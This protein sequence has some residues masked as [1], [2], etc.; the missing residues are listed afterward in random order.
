M[1]YETR[2]VHGGRSHDGDIKGTS[3]PIHMSSTY[4][5][6]T[7]EEFGEFGY[8]RS[9]NPTRDNVEKQVAQ[10][11]GANYALSFSSGM[12]A[13]TLALSHLKPGETLLINNNVYGGTWSLI[14]DFL[15]EKD[16]NIEIVTNFNELD[17][18]SLGPDVSTIFLET[19]SNP[20]LEI[21]DI[22]KVTQH[23]KKSGITVIVD[24]TFMTSYLQKPLDLGADMVVYSATK[25]Y[26]GHADLLAG[27]L[28]L[29]DNDLYQELKFIQKHLGSI[30]SPF[31]S[32]LLNRGI[33][34][35]PL[36]MDRQ[37]KNT[38]AI[39]NFL[40]GQEINAGLYYPGLS[41]NAGY[42]IQ[43]KQARGNGALFS[44]LV[45]E[46]YDVDKFCTS[47]EIFDLAVSLGGIESLVCVPAMMTHETYSQ[48]HLD[49]IGITKN[50]VRFAVGVENVEDLIVDIEQAISKA[51]K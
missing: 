32:F 18:S 29:N 4:V 3:F 47:L 40:E 28:V 50:L 31:D 42:E 51:K 9:G 20:L 15:K 24:N 41:S 17:F 10:L 35:L 43:K 34:T 39:L 11:E 36:R 2:S 48:E 22:E 27:L 14:K 21:I 8:V 46:A 12:G 45:D 49:S 6:D 25:Y 7:I 16:I 37:Q 19:P 13:I 5:Q 30:L 44:M 33:K 26:G 23:A 38:A 1:K